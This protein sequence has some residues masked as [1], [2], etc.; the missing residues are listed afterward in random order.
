MK[1]APNTNSNESAPDKADY[2]VGI[3]PARINTVIACVLARLLEGDSLTGM[4]SVF[5]QST[6]R[7]SAFVHRLS[8]RYGWAIE[9]TTLVA[10][11]ND[12]RI[13]YISS[14][15]LP[16]AVIAL[17]F[18]TG[19]RDWIDKVNK[20][21]AERKNHSNSC[22]SKAAK[23]NAARLPDPRQINLWEGK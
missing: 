17:A 3:R 16:S 7:L 2:T 9:S 1:S 10:G 13:A 20:A 18:K 11:T 8:S 15:W 4:E 12:G 21:R 5:K 14:Y 22:K 19:S 23:I 6:T